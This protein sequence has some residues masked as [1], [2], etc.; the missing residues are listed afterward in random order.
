MH[1]QDTFGSRTWKGAVLVLVILVVLVVFYL[2]SGSSAPAVEFEL[3]RCERTEEVEG[4]PDGGIRCRAYL[5]PDASDKQIRMVSKRINKRVRF[6]HN[7]PVG[8]ILFFGSRNRAEGRARQSAAKVI[9]DEER[10]EIIRD[11]GEK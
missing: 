9:H 1:S 2:I 7:G 8:V 3:I 4:A 5:Q 11:P 6:E 10:Y